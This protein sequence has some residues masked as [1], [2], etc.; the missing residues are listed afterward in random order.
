MTLKGDPLLNRLEALRRRNSQPADAKVGIKSVFT[1]AIEYRADQALVT[2]VANTAAVDLYNT[3]IVPEGCATDED[4][5]PRYLAQGRAVFLDHNYGALPIGTI[6]GM[7]LRDGAWRVTF[8]LHG[9]TQESRDMMALYALGDDNPVK[10]VSIGFVE[11]SGGRPTEDEEDQYGP[12]DYIYRSW[13]WLELSATAIPANP[14]GWVDSVTPS[15]SDP[16][17]SRVAALAGSGAISTRMAR[18]LGLPC[19]PADI[20]KRRVLSIPRTVQI[21]A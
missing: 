17:R 8:A 9:R 2:A 11:L 21:G 1:E 7:A 4:G 19:A 5:R 3:V 10:G 20:A 15:L 16:Q 13:L 12:H 6:R 14:D 18:S